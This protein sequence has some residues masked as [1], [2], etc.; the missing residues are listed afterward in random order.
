MCWLCYVD[1]VSLKKECFYFFYPM[2]VL[3]IKKKKKSI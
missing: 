2:A 3:L 1:S